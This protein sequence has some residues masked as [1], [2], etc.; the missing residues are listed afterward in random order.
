MFID[1]GEITL[2]K[3]SFLSLNKNAKVRCFSNISPRSN[4]EATAGTL[5]QFIVYRN[6][7]GKTR[8][9]L[10]QSIFITLYQYYKI[11]PVRENFKT[12]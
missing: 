10:A 9:D 11:L 8:D 5:F 2:I 3:N 1:N 4:R 12:G 7:K 6:K